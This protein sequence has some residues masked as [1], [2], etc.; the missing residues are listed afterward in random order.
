MDT[1][2]IRAAT[3]AIAPVVLAAALLW[4]PPIPG[5]LPDDAA[6]AEHVAHD[7][8][9]WGLAHLAAAV[10][11]AF[12]ILG[13]IAVRGYLRDAGDAWA[14]WSQRGPDDRSTTA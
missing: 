11:S 8:T 10:A 7:P 5:R 12:L 9:R 1:N 2:K 3:V 6:V 13:F 4:H 14:M